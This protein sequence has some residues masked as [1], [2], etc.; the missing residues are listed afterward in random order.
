MWVVVLMLSFQYSDHT[1]S[2]TRGWTS[3]FTALPFAST[4]P[5]SVGSEAELVPTDA[6][7]MALMLTAQ[8]KV[9]CGNVRD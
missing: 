2:C 5:R 6:M 3:T 1:S 4:M 8:T 7:M 9:D